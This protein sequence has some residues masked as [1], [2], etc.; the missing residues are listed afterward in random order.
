MN[1][2]RKGPRGSPGSVDL[3][4]LAVRELSLEELGEMEEPMP[5]NKTQANCIQ[6]DTFTH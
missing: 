6:V 4:P 2:V 5:I 1:F 3:R